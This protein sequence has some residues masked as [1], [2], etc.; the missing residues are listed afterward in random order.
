MHIIPV[1]TCIGNRDIRIPIINPGYAWDWD[2]HTTIPSGSR[3]VN[4]RDM[5]IAEYVESIQLL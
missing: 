2:I 1:L 5:T 3:P 4:I